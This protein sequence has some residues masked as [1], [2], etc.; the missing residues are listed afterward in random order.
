MGLIQTYALTKFIE[1]AYVIEL[2]VWKASCLMAHHNNN[3]DSSL[4]MDLVGA[5]DLVEITFCCS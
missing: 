2:A 1:R 3:N 5:I 4:N